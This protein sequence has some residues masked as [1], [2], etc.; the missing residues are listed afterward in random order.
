MK[1]IIDNNEKVT[2]NSKQVEILK[3]NF[4]NCF[5]KEGRFLPDKLNSIINDEVE[6]SNESY[7]LNWLGKKYARLLAHQEI[8][9]MLTEDTEHN[10]KPENINSQNLY[11]EG[12]NLEVLKHMVN[13]YSNQIKMIYIDPPYNTGTDFIYKDDRK[14]TVEELSNLANVDEEEARRIL[15]FT[16]SNSNSHSA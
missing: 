15:E 5:D 7:E 16:E 14:F 11:L 1:T 3:K 2:S 4:P 13:S 12:D 10:L 8:T 6:I 9:T